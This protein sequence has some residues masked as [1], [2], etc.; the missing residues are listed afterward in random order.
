MALRSPLT[1]QPYDYIGDS[2]GRPLDKG[3][4]YI[5]VAGQDPEFYQI[6]VFLDAEMTKP[7]DQP[8]R[9]NDGF[10][11]FAGS[12]SELY[13]SAEVYSVKVLD[14]QGRKVIYKAE[15][16]RDNLTNDA[17]QSLNT[18]IG[19]SQQAA[20]NTLNATVG[21]ITNNAI[22]TVNDAI[23]NTAVE[24]GVL[25]D[26]FVTVTAN[27]TGSVARTQRDKNNDIPSIK[28][29]AN[30]VDAQAAA[31]SQGIKIFIPSGE[32][33]Y[34]LT[35]ADMSL[36]WGYGQLK[37]TTT[38]AIYKPKNGEFVTPEMFGIREKIDETVKLKAMFLFAA[39]QK[40][41]VIFNKTAEYW[42]TEFEIT[43]ENLAVTWKTLDGVSVVLRSIKTTPNQTSFESD[44]CI[45]LKGV[46][47]GGLP[48][49]ADVAKGFDVVEVADNS[50]I[51]VGDLL[52]IRTSRLIE[53]DNRGQAREGQ[54]QICRKKVGSTGLVTSD[55]MRL[56]L[57]ANNT[58]TGTITA[59]TS[60]SVFTISGVDKPSKDM[61]VQLTVKSGTATGQ[62]RY[63]TAW[64]NTT[65]KL[66]IGGSQSGITGLSVGDTVEI[67][68]T[69]NV[70]YYK[71]ISVRIEGDITITREEHRG[72]TAGDLGFRGLKIENAYKPKVLG[73]TVENFSEAE[74]V[75]QQCYN[76]LA[77]K[78]SASG[79]NRA[80]NGFDGTGYGVAVVQ[81]SNAVIASSKF[82]RCRRGVDVGGT[83]QQSWNTLI[84]NCD[85]YA[86]G[87][88]YD[89]VAFYPFGATETSGFGSHGAG[90]DT[91]YVNC[92]VQNAQLA[93]N[94]RGRGEN[95]LDCSHNG[96]GD[97][98]VQMIHGGDVNI[99]GFKYDDDT[100]DVVANG[101]DYHVA[102]GS[103]CHS[104]INIFCSEVIQSLPL[105]INNVVAKSLYAGFI[106]TYR[107]GNLPP[108]TIG[109]VV[110]YI[111]NS[112]KPATTEFKFIVTADATTRP[113]TNYRETGRIDIID[114]NN[115]YAAIHKLDPSTRL[116]YDTVYNRA[117]ATVLYTRKIANNGVTKIAVPRDSALAIVSVTPRNRD[118]NFYCDRA[119]LTYG[120]LT[121]S[122]P[123][124]L[125]NKVNVEVLDTVLTGT[126]GTT[127]KLT[128]AYRPDSDTGFLYLENRS[129]SDQEVSIEVT[130]I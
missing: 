16:M 71:P 59:L 6:P 70:T 18:A 27:G 53:T 123:N 85:F 86:G 32:Y 49:T 102:S 78:I 118:R 58:V 48:L 7:I 88:A 23:N 120:R 81:C 9:T 10:V 38:G 107:E 98:C 99:N 56:G 72:A 79:A 1:L 103:T 22:N 109:N 69:T 11:D 101:L 30:A 114:V 34:D 95:L 13:A 21:S 105:N 33:E 96:T 106:R 12:L 68:R 19:E 24:G 115:S 80:Y 82:A 39:Q 77:H 117:S 35:N 15:M 3:Q 67:A 55:P 20:E 108:T 37:D 41:P 31:I 125:T 121:D 127:G 36:F 124:K 104:F 100:T 46:Y 54:V 4:I 29:F 90:F 130:P 76:P 64:D 111:N 43:G 119:V 45:Q 113:I 60:S 91:R 2:T 128:L 75:F 97:F 74:V 28:D 47:K 92:R 62:Q 63:I 50:A 5:G 14:K 73:I 52:A 84:I 8:I 65:K 83:Q 112:M 26:T 66:T 126:T 17:L 122:S 89:N 129:G 51:E 40:I 25:A 61:L 57:V 87:V 93:F 94:L 42:F 110:A 44:F 116:A